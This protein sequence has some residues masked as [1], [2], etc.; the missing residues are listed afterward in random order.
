MNGFRRII[1]LVDP[2][3]LASQRVA[4]RLGMIFD[5]QVQWKAKPA[6]LYV[7]LS[8]HDV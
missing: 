6:N 1:S 4:A 8:D 2:Q 3:N 7:K 5:R